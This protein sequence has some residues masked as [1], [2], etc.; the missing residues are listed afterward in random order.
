MQAEKPNQVARSVCLSACLSINQ[1]PLRLWTLD[2][3]TPTQARILNEQDSIHHF[4]A[5]TQTCM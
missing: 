4:I 5:Q 1:S 3:V 2:S